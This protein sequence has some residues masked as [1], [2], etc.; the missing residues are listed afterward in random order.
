MFLSLVLI[1]IIIITIIIIIVVIVVVVVV[2]AV[3]VAV[4]VVIRG[5]RDGDVQLVH[6]GDAGLGALPHAYAH[7]C[8]HA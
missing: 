8:M 5:L 2:V 1:I 3:A 4:V 6:E 7:A